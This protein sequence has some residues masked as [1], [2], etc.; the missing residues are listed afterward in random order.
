VKVRTR[1][2]EENINR[3]RDKGT[4]T[5]DRIMLTALMDQRSHYIVL[6]VEETTTSIIVL[7]EYC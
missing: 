3:T 6:I 5:R 7:S 2:V 1:N 4:V